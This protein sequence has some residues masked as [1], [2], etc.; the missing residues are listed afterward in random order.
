MAYIKKCYI[1]LGKTLLI[2]PFILILSTVASLRA[3]FAFIVD[4][5]KGEEMK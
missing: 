5:L 3:F 2:L 1:A 4:V